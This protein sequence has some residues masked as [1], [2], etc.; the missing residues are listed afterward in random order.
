MHRAYNSNILENC[1]GPRTSLVREIEDLKVGILKI[2]NCLTPAID[3]C[4]GRQRVLPSSSVLK[5]FMPAQAEFYLPA[6]SNARGV[7]FHKS[8]AFKGYP[9]EWLDFDIGTC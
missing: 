7:P 3:A 4:W 1:P 8:S 9:T 2:Q 6:S 5:Y